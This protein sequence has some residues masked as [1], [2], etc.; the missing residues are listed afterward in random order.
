MEHLFALY[1]NPKR[2]I[3]KTI[4]TFCY[5]NKATNCFCKVLDPQIKLCKVLKAQIKP[6][7]S[8]LASVFI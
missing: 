1:S 4:K 8:A 3:E 5:S 6:Q 7:F 2:K